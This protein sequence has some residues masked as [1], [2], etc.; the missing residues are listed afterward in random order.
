M[1]TMAVGK[2]K[3]V[4]AVC[5]SLTK[6]ISELFLAASAALPAGIDNYWPTARQTI[7]Q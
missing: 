6:G 1:Y 2:S 4:L 3:L 7:T 5:Q